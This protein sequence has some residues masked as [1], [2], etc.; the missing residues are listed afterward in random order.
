MH[1]PMGQNTW[2]HHVARTTS[3]FSLISRAGLIGFKEYHLPVKAF[4]ILDLLVTVGSYDAMDQW[5]RMLAPL[6]CLSQTDKQ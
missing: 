4:N 1:G 2:D 5:H 3:A 6:G